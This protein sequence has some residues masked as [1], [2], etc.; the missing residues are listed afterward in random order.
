MS[1][2]TT[3]VR[4]D[5]IVREYD[6]A[7]VGGGMVGATL[8]CALADS[9]LTILML[10]AHAPTPYSEDQPHDLR[11]SAIS[12]ASQ[13]LL[14]NIGAWTGVVQRRLCPYRRMRVWE[15]RGR[16]DTL[17]DAA[18]IDRP[19]LGYIVE[20]RI[21]QLALWQR[22]EQCDNIDIHCPGVIKQLDYRMDGSVSQL[23]CTDGFSARCRLLVAADG[24]QSWVR[25]QVGIGIHR[26]SYPQQALVAY[27]RTGY[28]QQDITWQRFVASGPQAFLPLS[29]NSS[30]SY[31]SVVWY[32]TP[33]EVKRL[34]ALADQPFLEQLSQTFPTEL[35]QIEAVLG[36][37]SFPLQSQY[38]LQYVK[39]GVALI[40][41]A[42]HMIH[43]LAGQGVNIGL[44]DAAELAG[45]IIDALDAGQDWSALAVLT[46]YQQARQQHNLLMMGSM[47][48]LC[49]VFSNDNA[50]LKLLRNVGL[51]LAQRIAPARNEAM[52]FA[53]GLSDGVSLST[54]PP[55]PAP[56]LRSL[57]PPLPGIKLPR[58]VQPQD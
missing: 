34:A 19:E 44:L 5:E 8:A 29:S 27:V 28:P 40:G 16:G 37:A 4:T 58:L 38:A 12:P 15:T 11:V 13:T 7:I 1:V 30:G 20:N 35:G 49:R 24:G 26:W 18:D 55:I 22:I 25:Q 50:P 43:P 53:M 6:V 31:G 48:L 41:D 39:P 10:D 46:G 23:I 32:N 17:F 2:S 36:R 33:A 52:K 54:L 3:E 42:A 56:L 47:D 21:L 57:I 14:Q 9:G 45:Q 51:E